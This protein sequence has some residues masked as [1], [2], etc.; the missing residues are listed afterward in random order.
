MNIF[1]HIYVINERN[2]QV[3][4]KIIYKIK[5]EVYIN[6]FLFIFF[7]TIYYLKL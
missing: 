2:I 7:L 5:K 3:I 4:Y 6:F 1:K